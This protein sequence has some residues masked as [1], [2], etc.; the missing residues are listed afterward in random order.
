M[1]SYVALLR[2]VNVGTN[3]IKMDRLRAAFVR[4]G[5]DDVATHIQSGNVLFNSTLGAVAAHEHTET[6]L[7]A[8]FGKPIVAIIRTAKQLASV[9]A[10]NPFLPAE[11]DTTT[12]YVA[13][14]TAEPSAAD[15]ATFMTSVD[16]TADEVRVV[17]THAYIR[18]ASGAGRSKL[19]TATWKRLGV[20]STARNWNVANKL[21]ELAA[22]R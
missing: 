13:F 21:A 17:G 1:T 8:E 18:Y 2:A 22:A 12:L 15:L 7:R 11:A 14:L 6:V 19:T 20:D 16:K 5:H 4:A 10:S 3:Q 9:C